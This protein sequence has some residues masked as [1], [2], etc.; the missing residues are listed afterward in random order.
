[1]QFLQ[2]IHFFFL[3]VGLGLG[4]KV[5]NETIVSFFSL[6]KTVLQWWIPLDFQLFLSPSLL[7]TFTA[8]EDVANTNDADQQPYSIYCKMAAE[9]IGDLIF[10]FVGK[11]LWFLEDFQKQ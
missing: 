8:T 6:W 4:Y 9:F 1:M 3:F 2:V 5:L 11:I 7:Q 10:V